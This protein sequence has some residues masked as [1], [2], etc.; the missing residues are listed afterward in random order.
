MRHATVIV[1]PPVSLEPNEF[2]VSSIVVP[3]LTKTAYLEVGCLGV[4][5]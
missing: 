2:I 3:L 1:T 5:R 4:V